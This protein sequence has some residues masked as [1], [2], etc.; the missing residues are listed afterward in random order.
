MLPEQPASSYANDP[1]TA[2][3]IIVTEPTRPNLHGDLPARLLLDASSH[4][5][6]LDVAPDSPERVV[7]MLGPHEKV[8]RTEE[9][10][11]HIEHGGS[12]FRLQGHAAKLVA[13]G[14]NPYVF[15]SSSLRGVRACALA[16]RSLLAAPDFALELEEIVVEVDLHRVALGFH[17]ASEHPP[18]LF[19]HV[20]PHLAS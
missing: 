13:P 5:V 6:G 17:V 9:V 12:S 10:R 7:V 19:I 4:V 14:A 20:R 11:V 15:C 2:T 3:V 16:A 18:A 1:S 8:S